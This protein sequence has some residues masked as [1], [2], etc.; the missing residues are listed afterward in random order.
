MQPML[1]RPCSQTAA[2]SAGDIQ[3][4]PR[5]VWPG[6]AAAPGLEPLSIDSLG[7]SSLQAQVDEL[8]AF[9]QVDAD[10]IL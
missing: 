9:L 7:T 2:D 6:A 3:L 4:S 1:K 8:D 5:P 10:D